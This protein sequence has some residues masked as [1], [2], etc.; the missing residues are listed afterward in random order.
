MGELVATLQEER[1][2]RN[3]NRW[4]GDLVVVV[5]IVVVVTFHGPLV[6]YVDAWMFV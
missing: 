3:L 2:I 5:V 6:A 4:N 1:A